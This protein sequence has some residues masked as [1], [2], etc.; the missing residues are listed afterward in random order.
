MTT[1]I[2]RRTFIKSSLATASAIT[3]TNAAP[4]LNVNANI[5]GANDQIRV[6]LIGCGGQGNW[7]ATDFQ[8]QP[9]VK[10]VALCDV[11]EGSIQNTLT[12][13]K[14][15]AT[16][17]KIYKDFRK[18]LEDKTIDAVAIATPDHWH[19]LPMIA[20]C[21]AG[22][23]VYVEKPVSL[24][25][26][27]GRRMV[28]AARQYKRVVQVG[29]QQ[30]SAR[31]FQRAVEIV[32]Q[33]KLGKIS[34]IHCWNVENRHPRGI[35]NE[36]DSEVPAGLDWDFW[37][38]PA[39]KAAF[40]KNRFLENF[41]WFWDYS[42]GQ[43]TDWGTH[44][45]DI[46]HWAMN[47]DAPLSVAAMGNKFYIED[48]RET[49]DTMMAMFEYSGFVCT[50]ESR[51]LNAR[52][53]QEGRGYGILFYGSDATMFVDRSHFEIMPEMT[54]SRDDF[55][56]QKTAAARMNVQRGDPSHFDHVKNFIECMKTRQNPVSD[57][58][59]AHRSTSAPHLA[60]IALRSG[61]QIKWDA[62]REQ[63]LGD[64]EASKRLSKEY[65][66][67]WKL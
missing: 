7:D 60:N 16:K 26:A 32:Q 35:R 51:F 24:T 38:G 34:R 15:D 41:R 52:G 48:N 66:A 62:Q 22:K 13:Q 39:P 53:P 36:P 54:F 61:R 57:I 58:E 67:P 40:N 64:A 27:E 31:H 59:I 2:Q 21:Q 4:A 43:M 46:V 9:N 50:Y 28:E 42:G 63:I 5:Q 33:G 12:T 10:L 44:L 8:R 6:G 18:L 20:A 1:P 37:L 3:A 29:T 65:R 19:A 23:D 47:V 17:T 14:L 56:T 49:P 55:Q 45:L 25:I 11:Y 30:R